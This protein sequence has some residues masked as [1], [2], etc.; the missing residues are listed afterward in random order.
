M[1]QRRTA[2]TTHTISPEV[3]AVTVNTDEISTGIEAPGS[4][5]VVVGCLD[6]RGYCCGSC[7]CSNCW[8]CGQGDH[9][10]GAGAMQPGATPRAVG[11][12]HKGVHANLKSIKLRVS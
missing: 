10:S 8:T 3:V 4:S 5:A 9:V 1:G 11:G 2:A 6:C 12:I 7:W